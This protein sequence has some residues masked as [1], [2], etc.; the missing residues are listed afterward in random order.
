[1]TIREKQDLIN[2][3][4]DKR[5]KVFLDAMEKELKNN[6][7]FLDFEK[8]AIIKD[9][10]HVISGMINMDLYQKSSIRIEKKKEK[11]ENQKIQ[12][13]ENEVPGT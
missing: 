9:M 6:D 2:A 11:R 4:I 13:I 12:N 10:A 5:K 1:M 3:E 8:S 7:A